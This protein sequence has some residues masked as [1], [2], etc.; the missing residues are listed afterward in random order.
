MRKQHD[1][2]RNQR[3]VSIFQQWLD[4]VFEVLIVGG[5]IWTDLQHGLLP[6]LALAVGLAIGLPIGAIRGRFMY[7]RSIGKGG[8]I[9]VERNA[10]EI[11][12]LFVLIIIKLA[13]HKISAKPTSPINL[14]VVALLGVG[15]ASSIGRVV[16]ITVRHYQSSRSTTSPSADLD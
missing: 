6:W 13:A 10:A 7:V 15:L 14:I 12:V 9:V 5:V 4:P 2:A 1:L 16:Y 8:K 11:S 3:A